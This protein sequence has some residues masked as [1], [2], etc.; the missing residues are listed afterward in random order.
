MIERLRLIPMN[1][2]KFVGGLNQRVAQQ[3]LYDDVSED[4]NLS[5]SLA[6]P[7]KINQLEKR[8]SGLYAFN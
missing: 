5:T 8:G 3:M 4:Q 7:I 2:D 6:K 1:K